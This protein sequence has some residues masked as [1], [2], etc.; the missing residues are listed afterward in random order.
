MQQHSSTIARHR[1]LEKPAHTL[2]G[3][4]EALWCNSQNG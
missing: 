1:S 2:L 3:T 4:K